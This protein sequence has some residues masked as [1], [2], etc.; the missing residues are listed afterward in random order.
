MNRRVR[1]LNP[2]NPVCSRVHG[3]SVNPPEFPLP[4]SGINSLIF[5]H[6]KK[7]HAT[8]KKNSVVSATAST[9]A[10]FRIAFTI[11]RLIHE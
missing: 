4:D 5:N 9:S 10:F 6:P 8:T 11:K 7:N 2:S 1:E 3:R